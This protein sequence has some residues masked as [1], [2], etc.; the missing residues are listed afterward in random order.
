MKSIT[1]LLLTLGL[2][3]CANTGAN[4]T[5]IV[6]GP[7]NSAF[8]ADLSACQTLATERGYFNDDTKSDAFL[9]A[10]LGALIGA[11]DGDVLG[12]AIV[13]GATG[14][15]AGAYKAKDERKSVVVACMRNRGHQVAG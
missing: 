7:K 5:P 11:V 13:G 4:Y 12:G 1:L 10:A 9:G 6:D 8:Y 15:A 3:A 2:A 14:T